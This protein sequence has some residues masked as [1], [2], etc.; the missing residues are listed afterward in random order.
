MPN[1]VIKECPKDEWTQVT[2]TSG[3]GVTSGII[4]LQD[5]S[6]NVYLQTYRV[7]GDPAPTDKTD[8]TPI[9][10]KS[11]PISS[12]V[13]IDVYIQPVSEDGVVRV[14]T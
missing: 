11:I 14:D 10:G 8:A 3:T 13:P 9:H 4:W 12:S 2:T 1:P 5:K 6:P 7:E